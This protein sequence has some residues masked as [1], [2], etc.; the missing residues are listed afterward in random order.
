M[1]PLLVGLTVLLI[2]DSHITFKNSLLATLPDELARQGAKVV[3]YGLCSSKPEDWV[4]EKPANACGYTMRVGVEPI[5]LFMGKDQAPPNMTALVAQWHPNAVIAVFGDTIAGYGQKALPREWIDEQVRALVGQIGSANCIWV[6]PT[7]GQFNPRYGKTDQRATEAAA[8]LKQDVAPCH[9]IDST[10][11]FQ[12]GK[13]E[14][15][16][17]VHLTA[18][19]YHTWGTDLSKAI[20]PLLAQKQ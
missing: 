17:G 12:P 3:T 18:E 10:T 19:F 20:I 8:F 15:E 6:G 14:T 7:W 9:Y 5:K 13:V 11:M 1:H 2:G 4:D 16:D